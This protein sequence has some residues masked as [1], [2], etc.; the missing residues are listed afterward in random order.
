MWL[1]LTATTTESLAS[2][3]SETLRLAYWFG[4]NT[5]PSEALE[6]ISR[7]GSEAASVTAGHL[8]RH[9]ADQFARKGDAYP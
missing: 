5:S 1:G 7:G 6:G 8:F 9:L 2:R 3:S 4:W